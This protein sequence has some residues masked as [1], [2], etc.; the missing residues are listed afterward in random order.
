MQ[1]YQEKSSEVGTDPLGAVRT[2]RNNLRVMSLEHRD[3]DEPVK[4]HL[5]QAACD[6]LSKAEKQLVDLSHKRSDAVV[7][8]DS[9]QA[10]KT[11]K[12]MERV[13]SDAIRNAYSDLIMD[14]GTMKAFGVNSK[15]TP[16]KNPMPPDDW[17]PMTPM[18][19]R[20]RAETPKGRKTESRQS[21]RGNNDNGERRMSVQSAERRVIP[22]EERKPKPTKRNQRL[23]EVGHVPEAIPVATP[24]SGGST[25]QDDP[26][27][28]PTYVG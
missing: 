20:K 22:T 17:R 18:K 2:L 3:K 19:P 24:L 13:K 21:L 8:G 10:E 11:S 26:Y 9:K 23:A 1:G 15:W 7:R 25:V 27:K 16:D 28:M 6:D 5:C 4:A 14:D 12:D